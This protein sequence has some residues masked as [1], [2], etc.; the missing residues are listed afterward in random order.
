MPEHG[1]SPR[2]G[3]FA[4]FNQFFRDN[5]GTHVRL[6]ERTALLRS[7]QRPLVSA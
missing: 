6:L 4:D 7:R 1:A 2:R 3:P 5:P